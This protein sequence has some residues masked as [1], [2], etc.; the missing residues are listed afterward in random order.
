MSDFETV[1]ATENQAARRGVSGEPGTPGRAGRP[2]RARS[3]AGDAWRDLRRNP[4]FWI[5]LLLVVLVAAMAVAPGLFAANDPRDCVLSRQHAGPSGGAIFGYDFQ[6]CDTFARAVYGARAS[7]LVGALSALI[8]GVIALV[9]GMLAGY[10]GGWVDAVLS[11]VIDIVLGIPL[12]L[13]AIV[14]LKRVSTSGDTVRLFAV[15]LVLALLGWTTAARVVRSSVITAREQDYVAAARMLGAGNGRIMWRHILPNALAPAIVV[16][17]IALGSFIAA[18]AT[19]SFL[20]IGLKA[21]TISWGIDIDA[22]RVHMRESATPL[23]VPSTFL[24]L[25]VLAFIM[26]GDAI[27]D[28]FD[29]K[30]R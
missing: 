6:G 11:R 8:T 9:V 7:L 18:E 2:D 13:A 15:I 26:L 19:L 4:V 23:I 5:S 22:G 27:R 29:P 14:L 21:P 24:A 30:L 20:G 16:L 25:T 1:A 12:L 3:L 28:A 17:T 10:F